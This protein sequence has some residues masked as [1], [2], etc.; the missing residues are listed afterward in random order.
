[1][2]RQTA[3]RGDK[4]NIKPHVQPVKI[5]PLL[6]KGFEGARHAA[7]L[8]RAYRLDRIGE[9]RARLYLGGD[10]HAP[11]AGDDVHFANR[12]AIAPRQNAIP[13][14]AE[15]RRRSEFRPA[16][17]KVGAAPFVQPRGFRMM[18]QNIPSPK[19]FR[20]PS[21]QFTCPP[22]RR[23][24]VF[25]IRTARNING[26]D[27]V[28][29]G[30]SDRAADFRPGWKFFNL[31]C[32]L[33]LALLFLAAC[34]PASVAEKDRTDISKDSTGQAGGESADDA[35]G[36]SAPLDETAPDPLS[37]L[38]APSAPVVGLRAP[39]DPAAPEPI[40]IALLLPLSGSAAGVGQ[41]L[42]NAANMAL[43]D[44]RNPNIRLMTFDTASTPRGAESAAAEALVGGAELI[45]G[46][47]FSSSVSTIKPLAAGRGVNVITFST[48]TAV[49]GDGVYV[50][51]LTVGQQVRRV[52][53]FA[54]RQ[55]RQAFAVLAPQSPY[56]DAA[57][58]NVRIVTQELGLTLERT[59]RYPA[60]LAPGAPELHDIAKALGD[61][62]ARQRALD[63][64]IR[65]A[66][67]KDD[68]ASQAYVRRL[69][70]L[71]TFGDVP[72]DA[73]IIPEGGA[74]LKE[75]APLLS[76]YDIDPEIVQFIGTGLW[77]DPSLSAEPALV[78]GWFAAPSPQT[79]A[80]F[81]QRF[82]AAYGYH[83]ARIASLAYDA[84]ALAGILAQQPDEFRFS[85]AAIENP[86]GF[87]GYDGIFRF[88]ENGVA[89]RGLAVIEVGPRNLQVLEPAPESFAPALN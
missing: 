32:V 58:E 20:L 4:Q 21:Q 39:R 35:P 11:A 74:R 68:P 19:L 53:N 84:M 70:K 26:V 8:P 42:L 78:G 22:I 29:R 52:M 88:P 51:G 89:E 69:E 73:L 30:K 82:A 10:K 47:L 65:L 77:E 37:V 72:F 63:R 87:S 2:L 38:I 57:V 62:A 67:E 33:G 25:Q 44:L 6:Q 45:L 48:D 36:D 28:L 85:R 7:A 50:M 13:L 27:I 3:E 41:D 49:A 80:G 24:L 59:M 64:E 9:S 66:K 75:I 16:P 46:P 83:P 23:Y 14:G 34:Q 86:D 15:Q 12:P 79:V 61:Y 17:A 71:D 56:G 43:F 31:L 81:Q 76:Y 54:Y 5:R 40:K 60:Q 1:M 18:C 55:G